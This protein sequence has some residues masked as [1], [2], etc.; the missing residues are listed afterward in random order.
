M[1]QGYHNR[2]TQLL[3]KEDVAVVIW[4]NKI[5]KDVSHPK[6]SRKQRSG[7]ELFG[8]QEEY[9]MAEQAIQWS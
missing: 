2:S 4:G 5:I 1:M 6:V 3:S 7:Q 9:I 8:Q